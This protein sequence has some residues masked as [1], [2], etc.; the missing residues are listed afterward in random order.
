MVSSFF[1]WLLMRFLQSLEQGYMQQRRVDVKEKH[2]FLSL[3]LKCILVFS[4][5]R[6]RRPENKCYTSELT[7]F[8]A[9]PVFSSET[10]QIYLAQK[11]PQ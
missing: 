10:L 7:K 5:N 3:I 4:T 1:K 6:K 2:F 8:Q 11:L 9:T